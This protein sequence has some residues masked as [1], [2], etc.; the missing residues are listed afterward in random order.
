MNL[1]IHYK[2]ISNI[3]QMSDNHFTSY[4]LHCFHQLPIAAIV[5]THLVSIFLFMHIL[6]NDTHDILIPAY[7]R[8]YRD[9]VSNK[10]NAILMS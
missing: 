2:T 6:G 8:Y 10:I 3:K 1:V 7:S 5:L 9:V 4:K